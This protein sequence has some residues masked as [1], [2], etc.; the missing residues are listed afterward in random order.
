MAQ[1]QNM[2]T[3]CEGI[4]LNFVYEFKIFN[5]SHSQISHKP[6]LKL[7]FSTKHP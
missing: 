4:T 6:L 2:L 3:F 1:S 5:A 7:F